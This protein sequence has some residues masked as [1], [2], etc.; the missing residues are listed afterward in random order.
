ME[1]DVIWFSK[2]EKLG[3][4]MGM[5]HST[6]GVKIHA[7]SIWVEHRNTYDFLTLL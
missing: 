2:A 6:G 4:L 1:T 5:S 7:S 3:S